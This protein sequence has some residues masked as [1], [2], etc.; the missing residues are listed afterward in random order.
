MLDDEIHVLAIDPQVLARPDEVTEN[1]LE[2]LYAGDPAEGESME[3]KDEE[4]SPPI[5]Q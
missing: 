5:L 3:M 2:D 1:L 4:P